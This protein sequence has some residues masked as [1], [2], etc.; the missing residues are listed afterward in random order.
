MIDVITLA[1]AEKYTRDTAIGL[2]AVKGA[3][4]TISKVEEVADGTEIT[5]RWTGDDGTINTRKIKVVDGISVESVSIGSGNHLLVTLTDDTVIDAGVLPVVDNASSVAYTNASEPS[6][7]NV[8]D[9]LDTII[10]YDAND[11][12]YTNASK[13]S[14]ATVK[15]GIDVALNQS[16]QDVNYS[17]SSDVSLTNVKLALDK[18]LSQGAKLEQSLTVSNPIGSAT[19]GKVYPKNT[20]L[21]S[22]IRDILIKEEAPTLILNISPNKTLY[23]VV[24]ETVSTITMSAVVGKKTYNL[25]KVE[26]YHKQL[27]SK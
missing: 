27:F 21:E 15:D 23:D 18:A 10:N 25:S 11:I 20:S 17:N 19:N 26:F 9:A 7:A 1:V 8:K 5:F 16:A 24:N 3:P 14:V 6:V 13:P 4:C 2:G 12:E 22:V